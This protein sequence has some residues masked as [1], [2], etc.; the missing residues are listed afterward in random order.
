M[1]SESKPTD[2]NCRIDWTWS[3][4]GEGWTM[5]LKTSDD[6]TF[7]LGGIKFYNEYNSY[8]FMP[9]YTNQEMVLKTPDV[10]LAKTKAFLLAISTLKEIAEIGRASCRERVSSPV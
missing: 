8:H 6:K 1:T 5:I 7:V 3:E 2:S 4:T 10:A 9:A